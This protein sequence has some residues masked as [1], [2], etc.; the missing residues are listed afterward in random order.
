MMKLQGNVFRDAPLS[1]EE[2]FETLCSEGDIRIE[3]IVST[4]Q[5]SAQGF[6]YDQAENEWVVLLQGSAALEYEGEEKERVELRRGDWLMI[7]AHRRH[8]VAFTSSD[9][10]CIW[11]AFFFGR[12]EKR[13]TD[14]QRSDMSGNN[15]ANNAGDDVVRQVKEVLQAEGLVTARLVD[16]V[17]RTSQL[18]SLTTPEMR[19]MFDRWLDIVATQVLHELNGKMS[20]KGEC[21][22]PALAQNIGVG[23]TTLF[24][25]L[26]FLHRSGRIRIEGLRFSLEQGKNPE[27]CDC[28]T[29]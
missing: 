22:L 14:G 12:H 1:A 25:L 29:R 3:R 26:V 16:S 24:S 20:E 8:R 2:L 13:V 27:A 5:S 28:L 23:E 15:M 7:P 19:D 6:W 4:G 17:L 11:L 21:D 10:C 9:P 18:A